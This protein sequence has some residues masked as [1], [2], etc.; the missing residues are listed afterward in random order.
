MAALVGK[1]TPDFTANTVF[2]NNESKELKLSPS[3]LGQQRRRRSDRHGTRGLIP[4]WGPVLWPIHACLMQQLSALARR[5]SPGVP[6]NGWH[7][8]PDFVRRPRHAVHQ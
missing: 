8:H 4:V 1:P 5:R 3:S 7:S 2:G 6:S